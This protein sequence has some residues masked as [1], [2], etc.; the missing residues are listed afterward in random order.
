MITRIIAL[1]VLLVSA[2]AHAAPSPAEVQAALANAHV[3]RKAAILTVEAA[4]PAA[5]AASRPMLVLQAGEQRR[6]A[7]DDGAARRWFDQIS[8]SKTAEGTAARLALALISATP[9][10]AESVR[11]AVV[12]APDRGVLASL[13]A[14]RLG[15]LARWS[16]RP[17]DGRRLAAEALDRAVP[18]QVE[19]LREELER[20]GLVATGPRAPRGGSS[21]PVRP[22]VV[23]VLLPLTGRYA[24]VGAQV[25]DALE[26]GWR[27]GGGSVQLVMADTE[28]S[29]AGAVAAIRRLV[30]VDHVGAVLGPLLTPEMGPTIEAAEALG[31]PLVLM[32]QGMDDVVDLNWV[33]QGW[34]TPAQQIDVLLQYAMEVA[35]HERFA[36]VAPDS[37]YGKAAAARFTEEV[38]RRGGSIAIA[39]TY[40]SESS[41]LKNMASAV[42]RASPGAPPTVD[43]DAIFVPDRG[44]QVP[45]VAAALAVQDVPLGTYKPYDD[46]PIP[47][48]GLSGWNSWDL[49][50]GGG[51]YVANARFTDVF[52]APPETG[53][54]WTPRPAWKTFVDA[55][56]DAKGRTPTQVEALAYDAAAIVAVAA[57]TRPTTRE[58]FF[59]ALLTAQRPASVTGA[60]SFD[61]ATR[62]LRHRI[63]VISVS[64]GGLA[65]LGD[66]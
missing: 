12:E 2:S 16:D 27:A 63:E 28:G 37:D 24:S 29:P 15:L 54:Q 58:A 11:R 52:V 4:V 17:E 56:R 25:R 14:D 39:V 51:A 46:G 6:L 50:A 33:L 22:G 21:A 64:R 48:L 8:D 45:L 53:L 47:L 60:S 23:G 41:D 3:D 32:S 1:I 43:Y 66:P 44:R 18:G 36:V 10:P 62:S 20:A 34:I 38:K 13:D 42:A 61:A 35:D 26:E 49:I 59:T 9:R 7:G 40:A 5:D 65:P 19:R 57:A 55:F 30:E 31:V